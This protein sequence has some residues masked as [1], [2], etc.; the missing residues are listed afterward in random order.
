MVED[1]QWRLHV[2]AR[3]TGHEGVVNAVAVV[4]LPDGRVLIASGGDDE[5]VRLWDPVAGVGVGEPLRLR[6]TFGELFKRRPTATGRHRPGF[7]E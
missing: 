1:Q 5:T 2:Q 4:P 7:G 3:I 6:K